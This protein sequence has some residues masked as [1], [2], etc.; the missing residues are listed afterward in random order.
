M[1][2]VRSQVPVSARRISVGRPVPLHQQLSSSSYS[3]RVLSS[4]TSL[5]FCPPPEYQRA[6]LFATSFSSPLPYSPRTYLSLA[7]LPQTRPLQPSPLSI[8]SH[9]IS[10]LTPPPYCQFRPQPKSFKFVQQ[11]YPA[12]RRTQ[13]RPS[14]H[15]PSMRDQSQFTSLVCSTL[16]FY[17]ISSSICHF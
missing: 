3:C 10:P 14:A 11:L 1:D 5:Q 4:A 6:S 17:S 7:S 12:L 16:F 13:R 2:R 8:C 15:P 9:D